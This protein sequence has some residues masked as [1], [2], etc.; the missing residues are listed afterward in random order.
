MSIAENIPQIFG[1]SDGE[2]LLREL[3]PVAIARKPQNLSAI[4]N[5][6]QSLKLLPDASLI[7][8]LLN[9]YWETEAMGRQSEGFLIAMCQADH[10]HSEVREIAVDWL[11]RPRWLM[12]VLSHFYKDDDEM[13][14][15]IIQLAAPLPQSLRTELLDALIEFADASDETLDLLA[16]ACQDLA[17]D[18]SAKAQVRYAAALRAR[19]PIP[20]DFLATLEEQLQ[21]KEFYDED[22][23]LAAL[24]ALAAAGRLDIAEKLART[25]R[26]GRMDFLHAHRTPPA[27]LD[28]LA[29]HWGQIQEI[30]AK[31]EDWFTIHDHSLVFLFESYADRSEEMAAAVSAAAERLAASE[32][33]PIVA[34]RI[35]SAQAAGRTD[36]LSK[37]LA[38]LGN[39]RI[40]VELEASVDAA[41][42]LAER[43]GGQ[44]DIESLIVA[45]L[46]AGAIDGPIAA[47]CDGWPNSERLDSFYKLVAG[48]DIDDAGLS[49]AVSLKL[50]A[51]KSGAES[52]IDAVT[53]LGDELTGGLWDAPSIWLP[54]MHRRL[55]ADEEV[56]DGVWESLRR[57]K[58][59]SGKITLATLLA[60]GRGMD[61]RLR[62]WCEAA[63]DEPQGAIAEIGL[64]ATQG[65]T[66]FVRE[67]LRELL[68]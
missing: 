17:T 5:A 56:A 68:A 67:R 37:F 32:S 16:K 34:L 15:E 10:S 38:R 46:D 1:A 27:V 14:R 13:R 8:P 9:A 30:T 26:N 57:A 66:M 21:L 51:T 7:P 59:P 55:A 60:K 31:H 39:G 40:W 48:K 20:A 18:I 47:L 64:D 62:E 28:A 22:R 50:I 42:F 25:K 6:L 35:A 65:R 41:E 19:G 52:V 3:I 58:T 33:P 61:D 45:R 54:N 11:R 2:A 24:A 29:E 4:F 12:G 36:I 23:R 43:Y 63:L 53:R 49:L 44:Q